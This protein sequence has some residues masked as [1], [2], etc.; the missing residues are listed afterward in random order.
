MHSSTF[1]KAFTL[2]LLRFN[3]I[4]VIRLFC[5]RSQRGRL[6]PIYCQYWGNTIRHMSFVGLWS[7]KKNYL[8]C[9]VRKCVLPESSV[10]ISVTGLSSDLCCFSLVSALASPP[11]K[12]SCGITNVFRKD[13]WHFRK[14]YVC[15]TYAVFS[16]LFPAGCRWDHSSHCVLNVCES[17]SWGISKWTLAQFSHELQYSL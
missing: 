11:L 17:L 12:L 14:L 13:H 4:L 3:A 16:L 1:S 10:L 6:L 8:S 5:N 7:E 2:Q 15:F 9:S